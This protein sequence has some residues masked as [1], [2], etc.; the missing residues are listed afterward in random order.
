M[1]LYPRAVACGAE[2]FLTGDAKY[3]DFHAAN[4]AIPI[5]DAGHAETERYVVE[6]MAA[7]VDATLR[8]LDA[9]IALHIIAPSTGPIGYAA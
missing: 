7:L 1:S 9:G 5:V 4:D 3:H 8:R 6:S 2:L